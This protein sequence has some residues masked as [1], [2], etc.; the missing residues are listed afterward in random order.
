MG[1][2]N[3]AEQS[4]NQDIDMGTSNEAEQS[5]NQDVDMG[6]SNETSNQTFDNTM[7]MNMDS[8]PSGQL[9]NHLQHLT[10][11]QHSPAFPQTQMTN[12][13]SESSRVS[14]NM[15]DPDPMTG[16]RPSAS[17]LSLQFF[18]PSNCCI[19][20]FPRQFTAYTYKNARDRG[21]EIERDFLS[22]FAAL[23]HKNAQDH[24]FFTEKKQTQTMFTGSTQIPNSTNVYEQPTASTS[25]NSLASV[26]KPGESKVISAEPPPVSPPLKT[27][28]SA[29]NQTEALSFSK[30]Q[31]TESGTAEKVETP[32]PVPPKFPTFT[33]PIKPFVSSQGVQKSLR[34]ERRPK[35]SPPLTPPEG[36]PPGYTQYWDA[37]RAGEIPLER[38]V[39]IVLKEWL[40][41]VEPPVEALGLLDEADRPE[42]IWQWRHR[43]LQRE[44][45]H[46]VDTYG[47]WDR[48]ILETFRL[49]Q[50]LRTALDDCSSMKMRQGMMWIDEKYFDEMLIKKTA[51]E[52]IENWARQSVADE[53]TDIERP[54][55]RGLDEG[56]DKEESI[57]KRS[58]TNE[59]SQLSLPEISS[60]TPR[61][62]EQLVG[63]SPKK[64]GSD[65]EEESVA[66]KPR[67]DEVSR[68]SSLPETSSKT[69]QTNEKPAVESPKKRGI[70]EGVEGDK[71]ESVAKKP[72]TGEISQQP[73]L[74]ETSSKTSQMFA[75]IARASSSPPKAFTGVANASKSPPKMFAGTASVS[76]SPPNFS[77]P[78]FGLST[79]TDFMTQFGQ[80]A[81]KTAQT[82][83]QKKMEEDYDSEEETKEQWEERYEKEQEAK[84]AEIE[85]MSRSTGLQFKPQS[86]TNSSDLQSKKEE[87]AVATTPHKTPAQIFDPV[88]PSVE[89]KD[90]PKLG[91]LTWKPDSP[92]KFGG[93]STAPTFSITAPSPLKP[94][95]GLGGFVFSKEKGEQQPSRNLFSSAST[96]NEESSSRASSVFTQASSKP[97]SPNNA[98]SSVFLQG[99]PGNSAAARSGSPSIFTQAASEKPPSF[100]FDFTKTEPSAPSPPQTDGWAEFLKNKN[101]FPAAAPSLQ[102][103]NGSPAHS[104]LTPLS[105]SRAASPATTN[106]TVSG[107]ET[108]DKEEGGDSDAFP[109]EAQLEL[110]NA[111]AGEEDEELLLSVRAKVQ[112]FASDDTDKKGNDEEEKPK[113]WRVR[114]VGELRVLRNRDSHKT[115]VVVRQ[116]K[117]ARVL[118]NAGLLEGVNYSLAKPKLVNF[119]VA[120]SNGTLGRWLIQVGKE[121]VAKELS[122]LLEENKKH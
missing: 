27:H 88:T 44:W 29:E 3:E 76:K 24:G 108:D 92:I 69:S 57:A 94:T 109:K 53:K 59:A 85:K 97:A 8:D 49:I 82:E 73:S 64:R 4:S 112:E 107:A 47:T 11:A 84:K 14:E 56:G 75:S 45:M 43:T 9:Q 70:D 2:S 7:S 55:K 1:T 48:N 115:R 117:S 111:N 121:D 54:K 118:L 5:S 58:R 77:V 120:A 31:P 51:K 110:G 6:T 20:N 113:T 116:E 80:A 12:N 10:K 91:D 40:L 33:S 71:E 68:Q 102:P 99:T 37:L 119:T 18:I 28:E 21:F 66:K 30:P 79:G 78:Q 62:N 74:P 42:L 96:P 61:T 122:G 25:S 100:S 104:V 52:N 86:F 38:A 22:Q 95:Q 16:V 50:S 17:P 19:E 105:V 26:Q 63:E 67:T 32:K 93:S 114:G 23:A 83:K 90:Q 15:S 13:A 39:E 34:D 65:E 106:A 87:P 46:L 81:Q 60:K 103:A 36:L 72:R 101:Q 98:G 41:T 89:P 35:P